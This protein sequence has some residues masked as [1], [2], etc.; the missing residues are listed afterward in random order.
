VK[1]T[2]RG[3]RTDVQDIAVTVSDRNDQAP[4]ITTNGGGASAAVIVAENGTAVTTVRATD[5]DAGDT[6]SFSVVGG[7]DAAR[8]T[9]NALTG[10]LVFVAAPN[11]EAPTDQGGN[12]VY[13]VQVQVTDGG[14]RTDVQSLA[15]T[16][17]DRNDQAP[18]ITS[19]G[20][21]ASAALSVAENGTAVTTVSATDGDAGDS[22]SFSIVGGADAARFTINGSTGALA[23]VAAPNFEA[24]SDA[25]GNNVYDVQVQATDGA[26]QTDAQD[27]AVTVTNIADEH[28]NNA[29]VIS[30]N[31][32]AATASLD[33]VENSFYVT[34]V[35][36]IDVDLNDTLS[37][38][39]AGGADAAR[40]TLTPG[41]WLNFATAPDFAAPTDA[42]SDNVYDVQIRV[43][44]SG[45]LSD[46]QDIAVTVTPVRNWNAPVIT[47][48][49]AGPSA[50]VTVLENAWWVTSVEAQ[51]PDAGDTQ[52]YSLSGGADLAKFTIDE[53]GDLYFAEPPQFASP[54][55][56][57]GDNVYDVQ[58]KVTDS[59]GLSDVQD[60]AVTV[61]RINSISPPVITSN[62]GGTSA[63]LSVAEN[64]PLLTVVQAMDPDLG[65]SRF[66]SLSGGADKARFWIDWVA[67]TLYFDVAADFENPADAGGDNVYDVQVRVSD[68]GGLSDTQDIAVT[69]TAINANNGNAPVILGNG[70]GAAAAV[71]VAENSTWVTYLNGVDADPGD[72]LTLSLSG[73][74]DR[75]RFVID[76]WGN[77][78]F[79]TAPDFEA[80]SDVGGDNI[81]DVQVKVT[82]SSGLSDVQD[83]AVTVTR[84]VSANAPIITSN[85][86]GPTAALQVADN[87]PYVT[88]VQVTDPDPG[89]TR[90]YSLSGGA[91][92]AKFIVNEGG[93]LSFI[94][95]PRFATP[96]DSGGNNVY[97]VQ[98]KVTDSG[99]LS[100]VQDLAVTVIPFHNTN[101]PIITSN[102]AG[103]TAALNLIENR[104][105]VTAVEITDPDRGDWPTF[106]LSGGADRARFT[107]DQ[108]GDLY[109][110]TAPDF[111]TPTDFGGDNVYEVQVTVT[112]RGGLTDVQNLAVTVRDLSDETLPTIVGA[113]F[114]NAADASITMTFSEAGDG[115]S[116]RWTID[117]VCCGISALGGNADRAHRCSGPGER[118][119]HLGYPCHAGRH[120]SRPGKV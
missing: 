71:S 52:T 27:I 99:G 66:F 101:A 33:V 17:S 65:D 112:D 7:A 6:R 58:V 9:I 1:A 29:P 73:G 119:G 47:S 53:W 44:D 5:G 31:G 87:D 34:W 24:P 16:V 106:S 72:T 108:W 113:S 26:G 45:G 86:A 22:R 21:G 118:Y 69:V 59:G 60:L 90:T 12:N 77:L 78:F 82:D 76:P 67:G 51:D 30:S 64:S 97:D 102:G 11:F 43:T 109:F 41:G 46:L 111:E 116:K 48:S 115:D 10:E 105:Y 93:V 120:G 35:Q 74:A 117:A 25:D 28:P 50:A 114:N 42:G 3:G 8:F 95:A 63:A 94:A 104:T 75:A 110:A 98:V 91:D 100:D 37:F 89:D 96:A 88:A 84:F 107:L 57:G 55:D 83:L 36:V 70:A 15:V 38:S 56:A 2:D 39:I 79:V 103:P 18:V 23:F 62:G 54:T 20:G 80:P 49:G 4:V 92:M 61:S 14:G 68:T 19:N 32:A 40:F 81:Y 13:D 85:G